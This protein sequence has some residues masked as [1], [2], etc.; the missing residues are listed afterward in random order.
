MEAMKKRFEPRSPRKTVRLW[1]ALFQKAHER[2]PTVEELQAEPCD[3]YPTDET[4]DATKKI[5]ILLDK[6]RR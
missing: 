4:R 5:Q 6:K 3:D 2:L 1:I